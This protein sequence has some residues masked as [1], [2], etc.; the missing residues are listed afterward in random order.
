MIGMEMKF[1]SVGIARR[2]NAHDTVVAPPSP[3]VFFSDSFTD[4]DNTELSEHIPDIGDGWTYAAGSDTRY[5]IVSG[6]L[7]LPAINNYAGYYFANTAPPSPDYSIEADIV[8]NTPQVLAGVIGRGTSANYYEFSYY[9]GNAAWGLYKTTN[10][11]TFNLLG[12]YNQTL[13]NGQTYH[14]KLEMIGDQLKGYID[15]IERVSVIDASFANAGSYG[16][17]IKGLTDPLLSLAIDNFSAS[18]V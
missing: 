14:I 4:M 3:T 10:T 11:Y 6:Q 18:T 5:F 8:A 9:Y 7:K 2:N 1:G 17:Y 15:G 16:V 13:T 12:S